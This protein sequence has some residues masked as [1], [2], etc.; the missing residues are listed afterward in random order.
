MA[1]GWSAEG[2]GELSKLCSI[3]DGHDPAV[4]DMHPP[5][6]NSFGPERLE[7]AQQRPELTESETSGPI[8][9]PA[10]APQSQEAGFVQYRLDKNTRLSADEDVLIYVAWC[11]DGLLSPLQVRSIEAYAA[12]G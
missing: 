1:L 9:S 11:P 6:F 10:A 12:D 2:I 5:D 4:A 3:T 7:S 8:D